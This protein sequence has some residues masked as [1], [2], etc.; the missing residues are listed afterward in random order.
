MRVY[1]FTLILVL[2][3]CATSKESKDTLIDVVY[4]TIIEEGNLMGAGEEGFDQQVVEVKSAEDYYLVFKQMN[5]VN[6]VEVELDINSFHFDQNQLFIAFDK[7]RT[8]G[9]YSLKVMGVNVASS[10]FE[11]KS[12]APTG[13]AIEVLTQPYVFI[14]IS[15]EVGKCSF[16]FTE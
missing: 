13:P 1:L 5:M 15:K 3:S 12:I 4:P 2:V 9:G 16:K 10:V 11:I 8:T 7:V 6:K 14:S